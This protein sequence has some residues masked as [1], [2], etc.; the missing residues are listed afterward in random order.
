V[1]AQ[2]GGRGNIEGLRSR[3]WQVL[4]HAPYAEHFEG[5]SA[6]WNYA[7]PEQT[8]RRLLGAGFARARC[9]LAEAPSVP[10]QPRE[11]LHTIVLGPHV[12][13]LPE[14]MREPFMDEVMGLLGEPVV[15][16]YVR[17]NIEAVA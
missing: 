5:W 2:C 8:E 16:D 9:W 6:P 17:L 1:A 14:E 15:I 12:Q 7:G 13:R 11:F 10:A 3:A 4:G